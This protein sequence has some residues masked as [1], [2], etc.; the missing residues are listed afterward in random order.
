MNTKK[1]GKTIRRNLTLGQ[2]AADNL[3]AMA[4]FTGYSQSA[5][6]TIAL[7]QPIMRRFYAFAHT[8]YRNPITE[9][10]EVYQV[11]EGHMSPRLGETII[12]A[13]KKWFTA[14][15]VL[16]GERELLSR[17]SSLNA[18]IHGHV[19]M[20][21]KDDSFYMESVYIEA[22]DNRF[23]TPSM[24]AG[25]IKEKVLKMMN[26]MLAEPLNKHLMGE[27]YMFRCLSAILTD[28]FEPPRGQEIIDLFK[29]LADGYVLPYF[30]TSSGTMPGEA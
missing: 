10:L 9:L 19:T 5:L 1:I 16:V 6:L 3:E 29:D 15:A 21:T 7:N 18:Y 28:C 26:L 24:G 30:D 4:D 11:D 17:Y 27:S 25:E 20:P 14:H 2:S 13:L 12:Q 23:I 8:D 22:G